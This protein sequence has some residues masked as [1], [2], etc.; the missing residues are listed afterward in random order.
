MMLGDLH[1]NYIKRC[2]IE[3]VTMFQEKITHPKTHQAS[4]LLKAYIVS[5]YLG[6]VC[7]SHTLQHTYIVGQVFTLKSN[8]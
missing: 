8:Y 1:Y 6:E 2:C 3:N 4:N 7:T 5:S